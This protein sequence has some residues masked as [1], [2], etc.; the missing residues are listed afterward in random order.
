MKTGILCHGR[1]V[2]AKNWELHQWGDRKEG[3]L[4]QILKT[5]LLAYQEK[6]EVIVFGTGAS[7]RDGLKESEYTI[8]YMFEHFDE[9]SLFNPFDNINLKDLKRHILSFSIPEKKSQNTLEEI[10]FAGEIF[11]DYNIEKAIIVSNPDHISRCMQLAHQVYHYTKL[12]SLEN[13]FAVQSDIG[14]NGTSSITSKIVEMPHRG[15]DL[16]PDLSKY[17]GNYFKLPLKIKNN[18]VD[19]VKNFFEE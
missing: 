17:I 10:K 6:A 4:G 9:M 18:F 2:L 12:K 1:H 13:L 16:S 8:K 15:D 5:C 14:Y 7:E 19:L 3:L 11:C